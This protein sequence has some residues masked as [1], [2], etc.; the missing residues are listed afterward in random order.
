MINPKYW[1][2][3]V[4]DLSV[5]HRVDDPQ[6]MPAHRLFMLA[7]RLPAYQGVLAARLEQERDTT[8]P[9][10]AGRSGGVRRYDDIASNPEAAALFD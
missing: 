9:A 7:E 6:G 5:F 10:V 3:V 4:S 8:Q 2:D 1:G